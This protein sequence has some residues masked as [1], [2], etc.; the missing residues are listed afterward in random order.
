MINLDSDLM[1]KDILD[2]LTRSIQSTQKGPFIANR[3]KLLTVVLESV[4]GA[5]GWDDSSIDTAR[6]IIKYWT[7]MVPPEKPP[8]EFT[9]FK[10]EKSQMIFVGDIEFSS[11]CAHHLMPFYGKAHIAYI[12]NEL[13]V[14]LSKIPRLVEYWAARPQVQERLTA[15]IVSDLKARLH[16]LGLM[17]YIEA[18][19][20]CMSSRGVRAHNGVMRTSLPVGA[21]LSSDAARAEFYASMARPQL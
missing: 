7:E 3:L 16:P 19:H 5:E 4:F 9:T 14:G 11:L 17:V 2:R 15:Q 1:D 21:F 8:F 20:T 6:R 10:A 12:P 18:R 13:Q